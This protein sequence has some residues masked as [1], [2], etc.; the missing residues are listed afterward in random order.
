VLARGGKIN[1]A[2]AWAMD[3]QAWFNRFA[4]ENGNPL[5]SHVIDDRERKAIPVE[6]L[7]GLTVRQAEHFPQLWGAPSFENIATFAAVPFKSQGEPYKAL[8]DHI[9]SFKLSRGLLQVELALKVIKRADEYLARHRNDFAFFSRNKPVRKLRDDMASAVLSLIADNNDNGRL[10]AL[11]NKLRAFSRPTLDAS[12]PAD[13]SDAAFWK[14][15][16]LSS[17]NRKNS[18]DSR[19]S[20]QV[21]VQL[22]NDADIRSAAAFLWGKHPASSTL[23]QYG[24]N[25]SLRELYAGEKSAQGLLRLQLMGHGRK[26]V[27]AG[28]TPQE[29]AA[30]IVELEKRYGRFDHINLLGCELAQDDRLVP[31]VMQAL[32]AARREMSGTTISARSGEVSVRSS[33]GKLYARKH[34]WAWNAAITASE[35][36][37]MR[38]MPLLKRTTLAMELLEDLSA[39]SIHV[40]YL[41]DAEA[42]LLQEASDTPDRAALIKLLKNSNQ[43]KA[44]QAELDSMAH[45]LNYL[46][47]LSV[48]LSKLD[49]LTLHKAL[50]ELKDLR[51]RVV[52]SQ[53]NE[54]DRRSPA[55]K[56]RAVLQR[57]DNAFAAM[58]NSLPGRIVAGSIGRGMQI[59]GF[60]QNI[61]ALLNPD[62]YPGEW[63]TELDVILANI[64]FEWGTEALELGVHRALSHPG[65]MAKL[66]GMSPGKIAFL[67]RFGGILSLAGAGFDIYAIRAALSQLS[68]AKTP[69][70][71]QALIH[72][73]NLSGVNVAVT[74]TV[75][76]MML[77]GISAAGPLGLL[78]G[79]LLFLTGGAMSVGETMRG[80]NKALGQ[81]NRLEK[82]EAIENA[83]RAFFGIG[84]TW[85]V[86]DKFGKAATEE[87]ARRLNI[88]EKTRELQAVFD[89]STIEA[90]YA[91]LGRVVA[92]AT[93][94]KYQ[95]LAA[96]L[97]EGTDLTHTPVTGRVPAE[98]IDTLKQAI[99]QKDLGNDP[100]TRKWTRL[101]GWFQ[102]QVIELPV[103]VYQATTQDISIYLDPAA[104]RHEVVFQNKRAGSL[105]LDNG[106][107]IFG[108]LAGERSAIQ[109]REA[110]WFLLRSGS[111]ALKLET[112]STDPLYWLMGS[113]TPEKQQNLV[114]LSVEWK[115]EGA[116][117]YLQSLQVKDDDSLSPLGKTTLFFKDLKKDTRFFINAADFNGD[118]RLDLVVTAGNRMAFLKGNGQGDFSSSDNAEFVNSVD[119][120]P[121][122]ENAGARRNSYNRLTSTS[123]P[124]SQS[125]MALFP[126]SADIAKLTG[127]NVVYQEIVHTAEGA[128]IVL[129]SEN[130]IVTRLTHRQ[131]DW[132]V[133]HDDFAPLRLAIKQEPSLKQQ[134]MLTAR[135]QLFRSHVSFAREANAL[136]LSV[137]D[138]NG[139]G[140]PDVIAWNTDNNDGYWI[141]HWDPGSG[142]LSM[143]KNVLTDSEISE[144][145]RRKLL[146][147]CDRLFRNSPIWRSGKQGQRHLTLTGNFDGSDSTQIISLSPGGL[148]LS[149]TG[150]D[151]KYTESELYLNAELNRILE[152]LYAFPAPHYHHVQVASMHQDGRDS[153]VI[154]LNAQYRSDRDAGPEGYIL[155]IGQ[156]GIPGITALPLTQEEKRSLLSQ[157]VTLQD[158]DG[159]GLADWLY[160]PYNGKKDKTILEKIG[161][162]HSNGTRAL[163]NLK[164]QK[165]APDWV[166]G[167]TGGGLQVLS[168]QL[169]TNGGKGLLLFRTLRQNRKNPYPDRL[170]LYTL[171][172]EAERGSFTALKK[173]DIS[174]RS[175]ADVAVCLLDIDADGQDELVLR[176]DDGI[177]ERLRFSGLPG[178]EPQFEKMPVIEG[179]MPGESWTDETITGTEKDAERRLRWVSVNNKTGEL[180]RRLVDPTNSAVLFDLG[181]G[182]NTIRGLENR[183]NH[184]IC[185]RGNNEIHT[186]KR[187]DTIEVKLSSQTEDDVS[188]KR[189]NKVSEI[190]VRQYKNDA[191]NTLTGL[192]ISKLRLQR[193]GD[194][195]LLSISG[196]ENKDVEKQI[197]L[198]GFMEGKTG[199]YG[200]FRLRDKEEEYL[201]GTDGHQAWLY[202][203]ALEQNA[204]GSLRVDRQGNLSLGAEAHILKFF[205]STAPVI[206]VKGNK[207]QDEIINYGSTALQIE[208]EGGDDLVVGGQSLNRI[209]FRA[210]HGKDR[211]VVPG[212]GG[213][214][215]EIAGI[216]ASELRSERHG[217][218]LVLNV[219]RQGWESDSIEVS[220]YYAQPGSENMQL[221]DIIAVFESDNKEIPA[222]RQ[223]GGTY[224]YLKI[225]VVPE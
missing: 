117:V 191:L 222:Y 101:Q 143:A 63:N 102:P 208:D 41:T 144:S 194:S 44:L 31:E 22:E 209:R 129:F 45:E 35:L 192:D 200:Q 114:A 113:L 164:F 215:L 196:P 49:K 90:G 175:I 34:I 89:E 122:V 47:N 116:Q 1:D 158:V 37:D 54:N 76:A 204:D 73:L 132:I 150:A 105:D 104:H 13:T 172:N 187:G 93:G 32:H 8:L 219:D 135:R 142:K 11:Q 207:T 42:K 139:D 26:G 170:E 20:S 59:T 185:G 25:S 121:Y 38:N 127:A 218:H 30:I 124:S 216:R 21:I 188:V 138:V 189:Q 33:G 70:E 202:Q 177:V 60:F 160:L 128:V 181:N 156:D 148:L 167:I 83:V 40:T 176:Y 81:E 68:K 221:T 149:R 67:H 80:I 12:E 62:G 72:S 88:M 161:Y 15:P 119:F 58:M 210:G 155:A 51:D 94:E 186:G 179:L 153:I 165:E 169:N 120:V 211:V 193:H 91:G 107:L 5:V 157:F 103:Q 82:A 115:Q 133:Q 130:G 36:I 77:A 43:R 74:V 199:R 79:A 85:S 197:R 166:N 223:Q 140:Y 125:R 2:M 118:G 24:K 17:K 65:A 220:D 201:L 212:G 225:L 136:Q 28:R 190:W 27:L 16:V 52:E 84:P 18:R 39:D 98:Q 213:M 23:V 162:T 171:L 75:S 19:F 6:L 168:G 69:E 50:Q 206:K 151:G 64:M 203:G 78:A 66:P 57:T 29:L 4:L 180:I 184:F 86:Q 131:G 205:A 182:N 9:E 14:R 95:V 3:H 173:T 147:R 154:I 109:R 46:K 96:R 134:S 56:L 137:Q 100:A 48:N 108:E 214:V 126:A 224:Q 174:L 71:R 159:D 110:G 152:T 55:E 217:A 92:T 198:E 10:E 111:P 195:L 106:S 87:Q 97:N 145:E 146:Q 112:G 163:M 61:N 7:H 178:G 123:R 99:N 53:L 183:R 141:S